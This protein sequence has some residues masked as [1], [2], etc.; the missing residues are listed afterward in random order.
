MPPNVSNTL[1][2]KF[3]T[4]SSGDT[5]TGSTAG[6]TN[7]LTTKEAAT[8]D[9][10]ADAVAADRVAVVRGAE[11]ASADACGTVWSRLTGGCDGDD[12]APVVVVDTALELS[13]AAA[14]LVVDAVVAA[15]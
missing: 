9:V 11:T 5:G 6:L 3:A 14:V 1:A 8:A 13:A 4:P 15:A 7:G 12:P 10:S 2:T